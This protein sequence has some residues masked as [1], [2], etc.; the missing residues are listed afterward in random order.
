[1][2]SWTDR[3]DALGGGATELPL[4][5]RTLRMG[6]LTR[7]EPG[8][9]L[10]EWPLDRDLLSPGGIL[11]GGYVGVLA[12]QLFTFTAMTVLAD[13]E[14]MRTADMQI[15]FYRPID[16]GPLKIEGRLL[17]RSARQLHVD[18]TFALPDGMLAA[19]AAG[20]MAVHIV[21]WALDREGGS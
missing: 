16:A 15:W 5:N 17:N 8:Y 13:Y 3:L 20:T 1:M 19:R 14:T 18:V 4:V 2:T 21:E 7:W 11:Y 12:D 10:K 9:V 6:A